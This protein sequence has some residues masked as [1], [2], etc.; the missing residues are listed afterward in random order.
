MYCTVG[1]YSEYGI[2]ITGPMNVGDVW[3][4]YS[5]GMWY[6][7]TIVGAIIRRVHVIYI[8]GTEELYDSSEFY[9]MSGF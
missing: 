4:G 5:D 2:E 7:N 1:D 9:G 8:D 3:E 6:N